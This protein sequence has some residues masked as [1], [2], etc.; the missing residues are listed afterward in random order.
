MSNLREGQT[1]NQF[2]SYLHT[3]ILLFGGLIITHLIFD[4]YCKIYFSTDEIKPFSLKYVYS[5]KKPYE[6]TFGVTCEKNDCSS[7]TFPKTFGTF[8][9]NIG[10]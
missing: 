10:F 6:D 5:F 2:R 4:C 8:Y 9:S 1:Q 7:G 3:R